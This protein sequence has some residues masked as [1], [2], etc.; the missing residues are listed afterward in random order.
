MH[1]EGKARKGA[2]VSVERRRIDQPREARG[3][4][5][6]PRFDRRSIQPQHPRRRQRGDLNGSKGVRDHVVEHQAV[7]IDRQQPRC[8]V[9]I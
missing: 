1:L 2:A 8:V 3:R 7:E 6:L 4:D 9:R 5:E